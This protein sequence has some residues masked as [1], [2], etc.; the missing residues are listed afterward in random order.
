MLQKPLPLLV[1]LP[2]WDSRL[3]PAGPRLPVRTLFAVQDRVAVSFFPKAPVSQYRLDA[4][5]KKTKFAGRVAAYDRAVRRRLEQG[6]RHP[7]LRAGVQCTL[8]GL[9]LEASADAGVGGKLVL[10][11]GGDEY[12]EARDGRKP[13]TCP[14]QTLRDLRDLAAAGLADWPGTVVLNQGA[15]GDA[16]VAERHRADALPWVHLE[17]SHFLWRRTDG[18]LLAKR[19]REFAGRL[20]SLLTLWCRLQA[21]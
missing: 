14:P 15:R 5:S 8:S 17:F 3:S 4:S 13:V 21:W 7:G 19:V 9:S 16:F 20:E 18:T 12:G 6:A 11:N 2:S 1:V 10:H